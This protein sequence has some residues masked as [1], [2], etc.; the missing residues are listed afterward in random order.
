MR[1]LYD[2]LDAA[3]GHPRDLPD[4]EAIRR[5]ARP[6]VL[7]RRGAAVVTVL[8]VTIGSIGGLYSVLG[9]RDAA[10]VVSPA[11]NLGVPLRPGQLEAGQYWAQS[12]RY[13]F[14]FA[15]NDDS[16]SVVSVH[17]TWVALAYRQYLLHFQVWGSVA[18]PGAAGIGSRQPL[19]PELTTW[20]SAHPR[21]SGSRPTAV[22]L[23]EA[24][25]SR[26]DVQVIRPLRR[27]P[28]ECGGQPC[29]ILGFV[30]GRGEP[31]DVETGQRARFFVIGRPGHQMVVSYRSPETEFPQ[32]E[33]AADELLATV[34]FTDH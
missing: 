17:P 19:P 29:V 24:T 22:Q 8:A 12:F 7:K 16:W 18:D 4:M 14:T 5:R 32:I 31:V 2:V 21:L 27:T 30:A 33:A 6:H 34:Q 26:I 1:D 23:G 3:A 25:G 11:E 10:Q 13:P 9:N 20:L 28:D 15:T